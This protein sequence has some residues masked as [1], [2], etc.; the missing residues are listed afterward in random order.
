MSA[1]STSRLVITRSAI[2]LVV[3]VAS[4][5]VMIWISSDTVCRFGYATIV[6]WWATAYVDYVARVPFASS[7]L[8][9][10]AWIVLIGGVI[11]YDLVYL[12]AFKEV[13]ESFDDMLTVGVPGAMVFISPLW[14]SSLVRV[15]LSEATGAGPGDSRETTDD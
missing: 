3:W 11:Y 14:F 4:Y 12:V 8:L 9:A 6:S 5:L 10:P 2:H 1:R 15:M 13:P 7:V